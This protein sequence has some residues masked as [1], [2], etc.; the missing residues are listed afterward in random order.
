M[1]HARILPSVFCMQEAKLGI[2]G[3][4]V[5][6]ATA[7][8]SAAVYSALE[9]ARQKRVARTNHGAITTLVS[10]GQFA[11]N[12]GL[13]ATALLLRTR[14]A[15][16][17]LV[18]GATL[19]ALGIFPH[20][21]SF[22]YYLTRTRTYSG[23]KRSPCM[24]VFESICVTAWW[25]GG[26]SLLV[27]NLPITATDTT[28]KFVDDYSYGLAFLCLLGFVVYVIAKKLIS[29]I[30]DVPKER[31]YTHQATAIMRRVLH[32]MQDELLHA[33]TTDPTQTS[34]PKYLDLQTLHEFQQA[35]D[36]AERQMHNRLDCC[37]TCWITI[38]SLLFI[39]IAGPFVFLISFITGLFSGCL[40]SWSSGARSLASDGGRV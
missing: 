1:C 38:S 13:V 26:I 23:K 28:I 40:R 32:Q 17:F 3:A 5:S 29:I 24:R 14:V 8:H 33:T 2:E 34:G 11:V 16:Y 35:V 10:V 21:S 6:H 20:L 25:I 39:V 7:M 22:I 4:S 12:V 31:A 37:Q 30:V 9:V 27:I 18:A 19:S 36:L 15:V